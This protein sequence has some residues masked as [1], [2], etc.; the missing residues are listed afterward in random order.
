MS[1]II[2]KSSSGNRVTLRVIERLRSENLGEL[3]AQI[4]NTKPRVVFDLE[5][6]TLVDLEVVR[7]LLACETSGIAVVRC[8]PYVREWIRRERESR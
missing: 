7:F 8:S 4:A 6:V 1:F 2:E 3:K 5:D